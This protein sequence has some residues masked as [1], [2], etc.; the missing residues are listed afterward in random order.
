MKQFKKDDLVNHP[1]FGDGSVY[2]YATKQVVGGSPDR[3]IIV[4]FES[5]LKKPPIE[6]EK[7]LTRK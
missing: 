1:E 7:K 2:C 5:G 6:E 4:K 3:Y